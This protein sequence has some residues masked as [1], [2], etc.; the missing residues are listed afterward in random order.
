MFASKVLHDAEV[1]FATASLD[2]E[3]SIV[4]F[5]LRLWVLG[6]ACAPMLAVSLVLG[7]VCDIVHGLI[8]ASGPCASAFF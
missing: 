6:C 2:F 1:E 4:M 5:M 7:Y 3:C 8:V